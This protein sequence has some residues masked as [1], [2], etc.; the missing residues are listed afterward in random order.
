MDLLPYAVVL[1]QVFFETYGRVPLRQLLMACSSG[2]NPVAS[3]WGVW[4]KDAKPNGHYFL[5]S[6]K[7][8][9]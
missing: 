9:A 8:R 6:A 5:V 1:L 7:L 3:S 2:P 4:L